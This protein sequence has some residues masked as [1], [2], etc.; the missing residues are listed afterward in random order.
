M[1]KIEIYFET[2]AGAHLLD[3]LDAFRGAV[4]SDGLYDEQTRRTP[5]A[6][7]TYEWYSLKRDEALGRQVVLCRRSLLFAAFAAEA[8]VNRFLWNEFSGRDREVLDRLA[9]VEKYVLLPRLASG[10]ELIP[11]G[12]A[13]EQ[14]LRWLFHRRNELVHPK[15]GNRTAHLD[16]YPEDHNPLAAA[17]SVV[18]VAEAACRLEGSK[19]DP[20][21]VI[22]R[23]VHS[24]SRIVARGKAAANDP[25]RPGDP[26]V[27]ALLS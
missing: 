25:P 17:R 4:S 6:D 1:P 14:Q 5:K 10:V 18:A 12:R 27:V 13:L 19:P 3:A 11:R 9:T 22:A 21:S 16:H 26:P 15:P 23:I 7:Q 2:I 20:K 8:Y 24:R